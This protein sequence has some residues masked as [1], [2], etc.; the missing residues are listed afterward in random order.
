MALAA[1]MT[2]KCALVDVPFGGA[3]GGIKIDPKK[4]TIY[5]KEAIIR[6]YTAELVKKNFIGPALDV[7]A[8]DYGTGPQEMAWIKDT[9]QGLRPN[10]INGHACVTGKPLEEGGI[11]GRPQAT[12]LGVFYALREFLNYKELTDRLGLTTGMKDKTMIIQ[13][14]GN[15][16]R[17]TAEFV[18]KAGAKVIA[19]AEH[20]G[21]IIDENGLDIDALKAYHQKHGTITGFPGA[22]TVKDPYSI[23]ELPCDVLIPAALESQIHSGNAA[24]IQAKLV[25][26]AANGP[27][28]PPAED[29]L[30][31]K[32]TVIL[33]D[34]LMNAGGVT[35]SYF[36]W[37]KNL[38]HVRFG[39]MSRRMEEHSKQVLVTAIESEFGNGKK[40]SDMTRKLITKGG[41][42]EDFV[43]SGLEETMVIAV[44]DVIKMAKAKNCSFRTAAYLISIEKISTS[45]RISGIFP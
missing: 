20:D 15:V 34:L 36:E 8:P 27:V 3:K 5:E 19:L 9:Y 6:R 11:R 7:P 14:F 29:I 45:Y 31:A 12:G 43:F 21:G 30:E 18:H 23:L 33:P 10:D 40:L 42:E 38:N 4:Y 26:E 28:T 25:A 1:L 44:E 17:H 13:G 2:F 22:K 24:R 41:T 16:G 35:V 37:L 32:G 39:R